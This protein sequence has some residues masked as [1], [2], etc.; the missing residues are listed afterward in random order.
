MCI[1]GVASP[2]FCR[3]GNFRTPGFSHFRAALEEGHMEFAPR[4]F[5]CTVDTS[6]IVRCTPSFPWLAFTGFFSI[7]TCKFGDFSLSEVAK[8]SYLIAN[9]CKVQEKIMTL[10]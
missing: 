4:I 9:R 6:S 8:R 2:P 7:E 5:W 3:S 1:S 10:R